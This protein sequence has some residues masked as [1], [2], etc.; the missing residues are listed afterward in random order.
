MYV[1]LPPKDLNS[2]PYLTHST[3]TYLWSDYRIKDSGGLTAVIL[4]V[5]LMIWI[6]NEICIFIK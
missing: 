2:S 1:K 3:S 5:S 4:I 6:H